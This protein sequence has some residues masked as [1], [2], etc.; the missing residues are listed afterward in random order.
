MEIKSVSI[1]LFGRVQHVGFRHFVFT[2]ALELGVNGFVKNELGGCVYIEAEGEANAV[3]VFVE[4][5]KMGPSRSVIT[6]F[7]V[8]PL[9][10]QYFNG[11]TIR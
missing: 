4:H 3:D 10:L 11:F 8:N 6:K 2:L 7:Q 5:C 9:P 1:T